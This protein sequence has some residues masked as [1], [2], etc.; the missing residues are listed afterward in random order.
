[1]LG[2]RSIHYMVQNT[3]GKRLACKLFQEVLYI[4]YCFQISDLVIRYLDIEL[5][6]K[7]NYSVNNIE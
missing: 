2:E 5:I 6:L 3:I 7:H 4:T 1:M